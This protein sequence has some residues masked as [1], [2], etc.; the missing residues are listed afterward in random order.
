MSSYF[1]VVLRSALENL[2]VLLSFFFKPDSFSEKIMKSSGFFEG[3]KFAFWIIVLV[4]V[5]EAVSGRLFQ[6]EGYDSF[7]EFAS[8]DFLPVKEFLNSPYW[9][10]YVADRRALANSDVQEPPQFMGMKI[11]GPGLQVATGDPEVD[12]ENSRVLEFGLA[13]RIAFPQS[14]FFDPEVPQLAFV[15]FGFASILFD[16]VY[17]DDVSNEVVALIFM[18]TLSAVFSISVWY[19]LSKLGVV[20]NIRFLFL[21]SLCS[22]SVWHLL[23]YSVV[24]LAGIYY[25]FDHRLSLHFDVFEYMIS[26][27]I[28]VYVSAALVLGYFLYYLKTVTGAGYLRAI[29]GA[30]L[31]GA[32]SVFLVPLLLVPVLFLIL[33]FG[34]WLGLL[35]I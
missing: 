20:A 35:G 14:C 9:K 17:R 23:V 26:F 32:L 7:G 10:D 29:T 18:M 19:V 11:V 24:S 2:K 5:L 31:G 30:L 27:M 4:A 8:C 28:F 16:K 1:R 15:K 6:Y 25:S 13:T 12:R 22:I 3:V 34:Y 21:V 33:R